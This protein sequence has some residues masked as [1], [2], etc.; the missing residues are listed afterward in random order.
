MSDRSVVIA[1]MP[2]S[3][4][5]TFL[6]ALW[7]VLS[8]KD[9]PT[10]LELESLRHGNKAHLNA[11]ANK[12]RAGTQQ[13]RTFI[14]DG[15]FVSMEL[16]NQARDVALL[17]FPD[18]SG[19]SFARL[20]TDRE[21]DEELL[22]FVRGCGGVLLFIHCDTIQQPQWAIDAIAISEKLGIPVG[23]EVPWAPSL[24]PTQVQLVEVLQLLASRRVSMAARRLGVVFSAWDKVHPPKIAP[25]QFLRE[26]LPLLDQ[27]LEAGAHSWDLHVFG[28]SA[29]GCDYVREDDK[30][31]KAQQEVTSKLQEFLDLEKPSDRIRV[32][33]DGSTS[34]DI[35]RLV[36]W[37]MG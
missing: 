21:F 6:A 27:Y 1:G 24:A 8:S 26:Q 14:P 29:Q 34:S 36:E 30:D 7:H 23:P 12:W 4:K 19:E 37:A 16:R 3:G 10:A 35:T 5:T 25:T 11:L 13:A 31:N 20:W 9:H 17:Q 22:E 2:D 33:D 18:V 28:L 15:K 32:V